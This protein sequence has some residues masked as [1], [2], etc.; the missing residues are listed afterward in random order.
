M[1]KP[2]CLSFTPIAQGFPPVLSAPRVPLVLLAP[3]SLRFRTLRAVSVAA[4]MVKDIQMILA[5]ALHLKKDNTDMLAPMPHLDMDT[6]NVLHM[7][8]RVQYLD[9]DTATMHLVLALMPHLDMDTADILRMIALTLQAV[10]IPVY[11][12]SSKDI[13]YTPHMPAPV[14]RWAKDI[15]NTLHAPVPA[16]MPPDFGTFEG[17]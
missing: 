7:T 14:L 11:A 13:P 6:A 12:D 3:I 15:Q 10:S 5:S 1:A 16:V 17:L 9:R 4:D 8:V 2:Y